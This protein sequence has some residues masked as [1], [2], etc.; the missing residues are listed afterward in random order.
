MMFLSFG[1]PATAGVPALSGFA[2]TIRANR[3]S[4][5]N[6]RNHGQVDIAGNLPWPSATRTTSCPG[7]QKQSHP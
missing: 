6:L 7:H 4:R 1:G 3:S 5:E 2:R